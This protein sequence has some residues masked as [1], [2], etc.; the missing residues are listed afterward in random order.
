MGR[1]VG[2][3]KVLGHRYR[4]RVLGC[5]W[6]GGGGFGLR[7]GWFSFLAVSVTVEIIGEFCMKKGHL[8]GWP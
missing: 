5:F 7:W 8:G 3:A 2:L 1:E 4:E 6:L